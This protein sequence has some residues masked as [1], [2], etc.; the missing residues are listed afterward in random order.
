MNE[1]IL[2]FSLSAIGI[3]LV[4]FV[5]FMIWG[6]TFLKNLSIPIKGLVKSIDNEVTERILEKAITKLASD[7]MEIRL[8]GIYALEKIAKVSDE[9]SWPIIEILAAFIKKRIPRNKSQELESFER[10]S[11]EARFSIER[12]EDVEAA[13]GVIGRREIS[14]GKEFDTRLDLR[15]INLE[16]ITLRSMNLYRANF[17]NSNLR[18]TTFIN[19]NFYEA[20]FLN[21]DAQKAEF[22]DCN[23]E[24]SLS[25][26]SNFSDTSFHDSNFDSAKFYGST[27]KGARFWNCFLKK[28]EIPKEAELSHTKTALVRFFK[29]FFLRGGIGWKP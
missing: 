22:R 4:V 23:F 12:K 19:V 5:L 17:S 2:V 14:Y 21:I 9:Y 28:A 11:F 24:L 20:L 6:L 1:Q 8:N 29:K 3:S 18:G 25:F 10:K 15:S 7:S 13:F 26:D 27:M 16:D